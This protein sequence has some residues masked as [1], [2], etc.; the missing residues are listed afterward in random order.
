MPKFDVFKRE[1]DAATL[2]GRLYE[3][4]QAE[5]PRKAIVDAVAEANPHIDFKLAPEGTVV[6]VPDL[7]GVKRR[8][9]G[10]LIGRAIDEA[11]DT[12]TEAMA[13]VRE[14]IGRSAEARVERAEHTIR[15]SKSDLLQELTE[16]DDV[17][18]N[19][20]PFAASAAEGTVKAAEEQRSEEEGVLEQVEGELKELLGRLR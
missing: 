1:A 14:S 13:E 17:L 7:P 10:D 11:I 16:R 3:L 18:K 5:E 12:L 19:L 8:E 4:P 9:E 2:A 6:V 20:V 15:L